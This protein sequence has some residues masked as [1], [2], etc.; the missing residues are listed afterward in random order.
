MNIRDIPSI[1]GE[2]SKAID[3]V[4]VWNL[5]DN[6]ATGKARPLSP[7]NEAPLQSMEPRPG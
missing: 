4:L 7:P 2:V 1:V 5:K 3:E 6:F